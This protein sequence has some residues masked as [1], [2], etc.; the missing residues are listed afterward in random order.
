MLW[1][2]LAWR[3]IWR[4]PGRTC[5]QLLAIAGSLAMVIWMQN[6]TRGSYNKM[7]EDGVRMGS[8]HLSLHHPNYP[9]QRLNEMFFDVNEGMSILH[10]ENNELVR[11]PRLQV[12]GLARSSHD[13]HSSM[14]F[15]VDFAVEKEI[16]PLLS[17][18][19][20][21]SGAIPAQEDSKTAYIGAKLAESL[22]LKTG[23]KLVLMM[24]DFN[25]EIASR[26]YRIAGIFKSGVSQVDSN[27]VFVSRSSL[28]TG[29]GNSNAVHEIALILPKPEML[30][31]MLVRLQK[32]CANHENIG[33][34]SWEITSKQLAD[35]I[36]MDHSQLKVMVVIFFLLVTIGT[37]N[38]MLMSV[39]ERTREFGL[40]QALGMNH[41]RIRIL[42]FS[43]ALLLGI[44]GSASGFVLG[45]ICSWY[46]WYFGLDFSS[47][48]GAQ[49]IAGMLFE[50][51]IRSAW[52]WHWMVALSLTMIILVLLA[53]L[54]P[55]NKALRIRPA[56]AM[57]RF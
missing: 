46:T 36:K 44:I 27:T 12:A 11:L 1:V 39:I 45:S 15:G 52:E 17:E 6:L 20:R 54:Y 9:E 29:L 7:I 8:G 38:L 18:K 16:N 10:S 4:N 14:I 19:R 2:K 26:L 21:V 3:N 53:A 47:A 43:E 22:R 55:T 56:E 5:I 35:T 42:I 41:Q 49:E 24:Q 33:A 31:E 57:R 30:D 40:L 13:S 34:F 28:A 51:V 37:V 48:F 50:P 23:N 32:I 25:G